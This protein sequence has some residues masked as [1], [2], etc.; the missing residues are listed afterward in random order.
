MRTKAI[1]VP[2]RDNSRMA[3]RP[4]LMQCIGW[5]RR[6]GALARKAE[7]YANES[8]VIVRTGCLF[9]G[10]APVDSGIV[11]VKGF[12]PVAE[13]KDLIDAAPTAAGHNP[14]HG[15]PAYLMKPAAEH[16]AHRCRQVVTAGH[17]SRQI[18][19]SSTVDADNIV[20]QYAVAT[21]IVLPDTGSA[22][23]PTGTGQYLRKTG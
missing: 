9:Q 16:D 19:P 2:G 11:G 1:H 10:F 4:V 21:N 14:V 20:F 6:A 22:I 12:I 5:Q 18:I 15:S 3:G 13:L 23:L 17:D 7:C 8:G